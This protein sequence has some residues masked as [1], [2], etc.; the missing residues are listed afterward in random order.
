M[1]TTTIPTSRLPQLS[2]LQ[3]VGVGAAAIGLVALLASYFLA[4]PE[5]F[6]HAYIFG[7][8]FVMALPLGSLA[9]LMIHH[10]M[11]G[12]WGVIVRRMLEAG[13]LTI[14]IFGLL[15][16]PIILVMFDGTARA[17]GLSHSIYEWANPVLI[18]PGSP[19]FDP[20]IAHKVPW[21]SPIWVTARLVIFFVIWS[22]LAWLLRSSSLEQE[23]NP[24]KALKDRMAQI[25]G[26][27]IALFVVTATFFS[28]DISMSLDPHWFSTIYGAHYI[29]NSALLTLC[30]SI[31]I[32]RLVHRSPQMQ[33]V[34]PTKHIHDLGK[35]IFAFTVLWTYMSFGQFVIIWAGDIAEFTPWYVARINGGWLYPVLFLMGFQFFF[36]FF[37]LIFRN[38]KRN[39][40]LLTAMAGWIIFMR[41]VDMAWVHLPYSN[42]TLIGAIMNWSNFVA[43]LG[44]VGIFIALFAMNVQQVPLVATNDPEMSAIYVA[45]HHEHHA[46]HHADEGHH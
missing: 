26:F 15:S 23:R 43:P 19:E 14:P 3:S 44:L 10:L 18:T 4:G 9:A 28:F 25:S 6:F 29:V 46:E 24:S 7:Y 20:I 2:R 45:K 39:L 1:A 22:G 21:L 36:P 41:F 35:L 37:I 32:L 5:T 33:E 17:L 13:A 11:G 38:N 40:P 12:G 16:I 27:G 34:V 8:Y 31:L 42:E 30:F